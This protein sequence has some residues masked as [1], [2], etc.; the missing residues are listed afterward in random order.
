[1]AKPQKTFNPDQ[2]DMPEEIRR[3]DQPV[4]DAPA[5]VPRP[6]EGIDARRARGRP[7]TAASI[8]I[9]STIPTSRISGRR[10]SRR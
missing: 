2:P 7:R 9:R 8:S 4:P 5:T 10:T 1:M 3:R 6:D